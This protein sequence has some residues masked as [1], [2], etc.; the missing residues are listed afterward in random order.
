[1]RPIVAARP[2]T[3]TIAADAPARPRTRSPPR[4]A[5]WSTGRTCSTR[6]PKTAAAVAAGR[7]DRPA[8][9]RRSRPPRPSSWSSTARPSAASATSGS[10]PGSSSATAA[11]RT[12][13][14]VILADDRGRPV[15]RRRRTARRPSW[16]SP[17]TATCA[18]AR[19]SAAP[20][21]PAPRGCSGGSTAGRLRVAV[22]RQPATG[23]DRAA[24][25][26]RAG[27]VHLAG[28]LERRRPGRDG[29]SRAGRP[30]AARRPSKGNPEEGS[31]GG[32]DW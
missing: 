11:A 17:T 23:A 26:F 3:R 9:R 2:A 19:G 7:A 22:D 31:Q 16:S 18:T 24:T 21:R 6:C 10:R 30:D 28:P 29:P 1:M 8:A 12:A 4:A 14:D 13:D 5:C 27:A 15:D 32:W 25:A 20:G